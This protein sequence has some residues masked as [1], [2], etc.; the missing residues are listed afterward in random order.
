VK[1]A[2]HFAFN[3][4]TLGRFFILHFE[5]TLLIAYYGS[6]CIKLIY[7]G[8]AFNRIKSYNLIEPGLYIM[9][10]TGYLHQRAPACTALA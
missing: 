4:F 5:G 2:N 7:N 10:L 8:Y 3:L 1:G 9:P 6:F